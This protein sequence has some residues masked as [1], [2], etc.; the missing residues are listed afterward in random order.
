MGPRRLR[1]DLSC[2]FLLRVRGTVR[3][4][5]TNNRLGRGSVH[6]LS[7]VNVTE[8]WSGVSPRGSVIPQPNDYRFAS[9]GRV[10][11]PGRWNWVAREW[12][13]GPASRSSSAGRATRWPT[14]PRKKARVPSLPPHAGVSHSDTPRSEHEGVAPRTAWIGLREMKRVD[15]GRVHR[16]GLAQR[17]CKRRRK[18]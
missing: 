15:D 17:R 10:A 14:A 6:G 9:E 16:G 8:S 7:L 12:S 11:R 3:L 18:C 4:P 5:R 13:G 2:W 1:D